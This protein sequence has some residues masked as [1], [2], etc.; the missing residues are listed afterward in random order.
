VVPQTVWRFNRNKNMTI[1]RI[2]CWLLII[3]SIF[4]IF[5]K[6]SYPDIEKWDESTNALV[7][8]ESLTSSQPLV[9][10]LNG[11]PFLEKPPLWY[12]LSMAS[13][14]IFGFQEFSLRLVSATS[15]LALVLVVYR[16]GTLLYSRN[17]GLVAGFTLISI[18]QLFLTDKRV[19]YSTHTLRSADLDALQIL[20]MVWSVY[21]FFLWQKKGD[22]NL[23]TAVMAAALAVMTKGL[24]GVVPLL[25]CIIW[26]IGTGGRSV[27][28][29][30]NILISILIFVA[31]VFPWHIYMYLF[32]LK[33][34]MD[35]YVNY[36]FFQRVITALEGHHEPAWYYLWVLFSQPLVFGV[37][38]GVIALISRQDQKYQSSSLNLV[39]AICLVLILLL[40]LVQTK[41]AW[42]ILPIYPFLTLVVGQVIA[43]TIQRP[44]RKYLGVFL[45]VTLSLQILLTS[46]K[47]FNLP[48]GALQQKIGQVLRDCPSRVTFFSDHDSTDIQY[49]MARYGSPTDHPEGLCRV[50]LIKSYYDL[51]DPEGYEI[52]LERI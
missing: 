33:S 43:Q 39:L 36:H 52:L 49:L 42:Y 34:F 31:I 13:V 21:A 10:T 15:A 25:T 12:Y 3:A 19:L 8:K 50:K 7:V 26:V 37:F 11:Q 27:I 23:Y 40:T 16:L 48:A 9:L 28:T 35:T 17:A 30:R 44:G 41:L 47:I 46:Y 14:Q 45:V 51:H 22:K 2:A 18:P 20:L 38:A 29:R 24:L 32:D 1:H 5:Y 6:L 4:I